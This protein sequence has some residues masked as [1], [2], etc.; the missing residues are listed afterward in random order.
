M[1]ARFTRRENERCSSQSL[2]EERAE[3]VTGFS[4]R[5]L[6]L[7]RVQLPTVV[8]W[9]QNFKSLNHKTKCTTNMSYILSHEMYWW[10]GTDRDCWMWGPGWQESSEARGRLCSRNE[11][12]V[13]KENEDTL[14]RIGKGCWYLRVDKDSLLLL[15]CVT[16]GWEVQD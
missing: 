2:R 13:P 9:K 16:P 3:K 15:V 1:H 6:V 12:Q 7:S 10:V 4:I 8:G 5:S 14:E 11:G